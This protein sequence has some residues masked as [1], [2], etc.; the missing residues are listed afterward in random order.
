MILIVTFP[1]NEHVEQ[2]RRHL[3]VDHVVVDQADLPERM[4]LHAGTRG[5]RLQLTLRLPDGRLV[6]LDEVRAV[7]MRRIRPFRLAPELD[8]V[9]GQFAWS[10]C[11]EALTGIWYSMAAF[12]MNHP[13]ADE[14]AQRKVLQL[15]VALDVGLTV[16]E[17]MITNDPVEAEAFLDRVGPGRVIRK[18]FRN[19]E[20]APRT[21]TL[22]TAADRAKLGLVQHAPVIFQRFVAASADLRVTVVAGEVFA[23]L[24]R[25]DADHQ[26]DYRPGLGTASVTA[27]RLPDDVTSGLL[28]LMDR[29]GL[30]YGAIDL[31]LTPE[32]E[33]V[34][35]EVNPA[36]EYLFASQRTGQ[37]V[38]EAIAAALTRG[39]PD[40]VGPRHPLGLVRSDPRW[41]DRV[42]GAVAFTVDGSGA[43]P[44]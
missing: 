13:L 8:P 44:S 21:T 6:D 40:V 7:W 41:T 11:Q 42:A 33:Y 10:E 38:P 35:L 34:F 3:R 14:A 18:A 12:W 4:A 28:R 16:P 25:S 43:A 5:E 37:P 32:G 20:P 17:T 26:V 24:I 31:R 15:R 1:G 39:S 36:G 2:V 19:I 22:V 27:H 9:G 23:A 30:S 29:L